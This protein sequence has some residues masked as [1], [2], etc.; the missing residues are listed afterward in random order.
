[1]ADRIA[2]GGD[3]TTQNKSG[4]GETG[5]PSGQGGGGAP[6]VPDLDAALAVVRSHG[7]EVAKT[8]ELAEMKR[9]TG[10]VRSGNLAQKLKHYDELVAAQEEKRRAEMTELD[11]L[12]EDM[13]KVAEE[14][15]RLNREV[16]LGDLRVG[17]VMEN[18]KR[19]LPD[20]E[21]MAVFPEFLDLDVVAQFDGGDDKAVASFVES[22][23]DTLEQNQRKMAARFSPPSDAPGGARPTSTAARGNRRAPQ[24][25]GSLIKQSFDWRDRVVTHFNPR[26]EGKRTR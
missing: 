4:A 1:M 25:S 19:S 14:N 22:A 5:N 16:A 12:K 11:V 2:D 24:T 26:T 3:S 7:L 6:S 21:K 18:L 8:E 23:L 15:E 9:V 13:R 20:S 17:L 10:S